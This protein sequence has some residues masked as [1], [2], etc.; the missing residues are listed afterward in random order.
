M[1]TYF[2]FRWQ[3][4]VIGEGNQVPEALLGSCTV[5]RGS[6]EGLMLAGSSTQCA[7]L[8]VLH[9]GRINPP[10]HPLLW[11]TGHWATG[12]W[13]GQKANVETLV[14]PNTHVPLG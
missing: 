7:L 10:P 3:H 1:G 4:T 9:L 8:A 11:T 2:V 6:S 14:K 5:R 13:M 12:P